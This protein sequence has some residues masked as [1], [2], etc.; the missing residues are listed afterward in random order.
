M[1]RSPC[2]RKPKR[3]KTGEPHPWVVGKA[4]VQNY[5]SVVQERA[6]SWLAIGNGRP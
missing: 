5:L 1:T 3:G 6:K 2:W 4:E